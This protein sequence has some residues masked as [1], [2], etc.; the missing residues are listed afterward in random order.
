M[1]CQFI[2]IWSWL[3]KLLRNREYLMRHKSSHV[4]MAITRSVMGGVQSNLGYYLISWKTAFVP[5]LKEFGD[6]GLTQLDDLTWNDPFCTACHSIQ[7]NTILDALLP[8]FS[9]L[10]SAILVLRGSRSTFSGHP[11]TCVELCLVESHVDCW[12]S[13]ICRSLIIVL[14][15]Y[16]YDYFVFHCIKPNLFEEK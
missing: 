2:S 4:W 3:V 13:D 15:L 1:H 10:R 16:L 5:N 7:Q 9:L 6:G 14:S 11:A 12:H 8:A